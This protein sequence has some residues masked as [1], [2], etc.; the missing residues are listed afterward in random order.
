MDEYINSVLVFVETNHKVNIHDLAYTLQVGRE[1][2]EHRLGIMV[3]FTSELKEKLTN[4]IKEP[5][6]IINDLYIGQIKK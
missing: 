1:A 5:E 3:N 4:Y 2:M 6:S